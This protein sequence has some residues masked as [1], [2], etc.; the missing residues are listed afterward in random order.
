MSKELSLERNIVVQPVIFEG[1][2]SEAIGHEKLKIF[3]ALEAPQEF[4]FE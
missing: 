3:M 4:R 2:D 1:L